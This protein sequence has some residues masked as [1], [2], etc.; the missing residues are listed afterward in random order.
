MGIALCG[1]KPGAAVIREELEKQHPGFVQ[2]GLVAVGLL[3]D[4]ASIPIVAKILKEIKDPM[5]RREGAVALA[6]LR[7]GAAIPE[8]LELMR[9]SKSTLS[10]GA[11]AAW[12]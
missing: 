4:R 7:Q 1:Y 9:R 10:R 12:A 2:H 5:V 11:V 3:N 6:L 8:L